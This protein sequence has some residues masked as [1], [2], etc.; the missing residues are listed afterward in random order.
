MTE[1]NTKA[2][3]RHCDYPDWTFIRQVEKKMMREKNKQLKRQNVKSESS[4]PP[5]K[6]VVLPFV[7]GLSEMTAWV[8]KTYN[9]TVSFRPANS[10]VQQLFSSRTKLTL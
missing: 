4:T 9:S 2:A 6:L 1:I 5:G 7:K 8:L 10:I 3:L